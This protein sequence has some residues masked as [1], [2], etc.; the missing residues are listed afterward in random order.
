MWL[1]CLRRIAAQAL[2]PVRVR[3][4]GGCLEPLQHLHQLP[5]QYV[6]FGNLLLDRA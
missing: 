6:E 4:G 1:L 2:T 5:F 3:R